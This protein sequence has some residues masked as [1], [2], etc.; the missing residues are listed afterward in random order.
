[1]E[2]N[3]KTLIEKIKKDGIE[4]A[5]EKAQN[6]IR[7]AEEKAKNIIKEASN[8]AREIEKEAKKKAENYQKNSLSAINL[9][10]RDVLIKVK[11]AISE[12]LDKILKY[13][14]S[15]VLDENFLAQILTKI[16]DVWQQDKDAPLEIILSPED[17]EKLTAY[18][19]NKFKEKA[20]DTLILK[21]S[22]NIKKG[23]RIGIKGENLYYD[24]E[25][26]TLGELLKESLSDSLA[27]KLE[28]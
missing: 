9:A 6:I 7:E 24:L 4:E 13:E 12:V 21:P 19:I 5:E 1:M 20:K 27:A 3:L 2:T 18:L 23:F 8:K 10:A 14:V 22:P 28:L 11:T 16:I 26:E 25:D 15:E 17:K